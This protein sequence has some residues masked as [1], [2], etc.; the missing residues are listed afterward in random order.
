VVLQPRYSDADICRFID[1]LALFGI[2]ASWGG[3]ESLATAPDVAAVRTAVPWTRGP[4][5][6]FHI[7]LEDPRDLIA[8]LEEGFKRLAAATR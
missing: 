6:R 3:F 7:G 2:G 8:D 1:G 4:L 5:I